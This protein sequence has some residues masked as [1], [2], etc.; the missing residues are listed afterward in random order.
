LRW[1]WRPSMAL[2][3]FKNK[4]ASSIRLEDHSPYINIEASSSTELTEF[5]TLPDIQNSPQLVALLSQGTDKYQLNDG[6]IDLTVIQALNMVSSG[7]WVNEPSVDIK[8]SIVL[9]SQE[10]GFQDLTGHNVYRLGPMDYLAK[11][12]KNT[13]F[14]EKFT[15]TMYIQGGGVDVPE[16]VY[17]SGTKTDNKPEHGDYAV[18]DLVDSDNIIGYGKTATISQVART[19]NVAT[20]TTASAHTFAV[21]EKVVVNANDDT[22]DDMEATIVSVPDNTH[23]TY[24]NTGDDVVEKAATGSVGKIVI[25][26]PFVPKSYVYPGIVWECACSDA[27]AV[28]A[29]I[30][31]RFRYVSVGSS[32]VHVMPHYKLRT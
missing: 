31:L 12:G 11:A 2:R 3:L 5:W 21:S 19:T 26:A 22:F 24:S 10:K 9:S 32:D 20:I 13:I 18:F 15:S 23:F 14:M 30:Y 29:G 16:Y 27:K 1:T 28:P 25:L 4:T 8:S 6:S 17:V 7:I